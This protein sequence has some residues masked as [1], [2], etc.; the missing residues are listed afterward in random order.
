[1]VT[2]DTNWLVSQLDD[3][4]IVLIDGRG[5]MPYR[6]GHIKNAIPLGIEHVISIADNGANLVIDMQTAEKDEKQ[7]VLFS[8]GDHDILLR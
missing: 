2:V 8:F 1:M 7:V 5:I 4:N 3:P 6:F